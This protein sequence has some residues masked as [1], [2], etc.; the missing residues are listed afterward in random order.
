MCNTFGTGL[1]KL[2]HSGWPSQMTPTSFAWE[3]RCSRSLAQSRIDLAFWLHWT[4]LK[5]IGLNPLPKKS[6][7]T[8]MGS[9]GCG[10]RKERRRRER[11]CT[12]ARLNQKCKECMYM[13][14]HHSLFN[15]CNLYSCHFP[16]LTQCK[17][18]LWD[19]QLTGRAVIQLPAHHSCGIVAP[20][21]VTDGAELVV[22]ADLHTTLKLC[23]STHQTKLTISTW[24]YIC[25]QSEIRY[26]VHG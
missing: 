23:G 21:I 3:Q 6:E 2:C 17:H 12:I 22:Q 11:R 25:S 20:H 1:A 15:S 19:L 8:D 14:R 18:T 26:S 10:E 13:M 5:W 4:L 16:M 7:L 24:H 9:G